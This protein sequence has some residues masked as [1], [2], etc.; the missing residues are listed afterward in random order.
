MPPKAPKVKAPKVVPVVADAGPPPNLDFI[1]HRIAVYD[2][3]KAAA[4]AELASKPREPITVTLPDGRQIAGTS[5]E[6]TPYDIARGISKSLADRTVISRVNGTLWDLMRPFEGSANVELL[7]F[8]DEE[9]K[10]VYWH[11]SA[12]ILGEAAEKTFGCHLCFGPPTD[13]GFFY[14]FGMPAEDGEGKPNAHSAVTDDDEKRIAS[15]MEGIVRERQPFERLVMTKANL[16]EMF[17]FNKYKQVLIN[18][19]IPDGTSTTVYRCG[20]L[21]DLCLGPHVVDTGRI[22]AFA[23]LKHSASYFLGDAKNDSLQRVYG[24][25]FPDKKLLSDY[26]KFLE[27]AAKKD[28]RRIGQDQELFFFHKMSPGSPF[29]LPHGMRIFNALKSFIVSEY[30]KRD[31]VEVMSPNMFNA[32]LWRTSGHWQHYQED[33]F[34]LE[35]EKQQWGLKPM[36]CPGHCLIF[37]SRERSYRELPLRMAEFGVLHRNEASGALSGLTR[38]RRFIQDDTHIFCQEDQIG[39]EIRDQFDFLQTVYG[40]LGMKFRLKLSTRPEQYLGHIDTWNRAEATLQKALDEFSEK[41]GDEWELN[42]GD[43]AFY[44]PKVDIQIMDA[45]RRWHQC[46]TVQL[47]F[48]LPQQFNL[49]YMSAASS[50]PADAAKADE[51]PAERP[52]EA[53]AAAEAAPAEA[54]S[55]EAAPADG[56]IPAGGPVVLPL[57][58]GYA[59][60]VMIHRAVLGSFERFIATLSEHFGGKWPFWM[61]PRQILLVPV[62]AD[63]EDYVR[64]VH[65]VLKAKGFYVDSDLGANT[66]N[67]KIRNGQ[68]LQY[69]YIFVLGSKEM[70][71]RSVSIRI[72]DSKGDLTTLSLDQ[73]VERLVKLREDKGLDMDLSDQVGTK[74]EEKTEKTEKAEN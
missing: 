32:D 26:M 22:K 41:T 33:M 46:A 35:I 45:L 7:D 10:R 42:P 24:I 65:K 73:V 47:D 53:P 63:A 34:T 69:N 57:A 68:V 62:M 58:P 28:H 60:P 1:P 38:V 21:I 40:K 74:V 27:E 11:S 37:G 23:V 18:S 30:H 2:R 17:K 39:E 64:E 49:S 6:T 20:P 3:L 67:K 8:E 4:D 44:G 66:M 43:G 50:N 56:A 55:A 15:L 31:Y 48:Q 70:Q 51:T 12:H 52:A 25:S 5:Y 19:K 71:D 54:A 16:L 29:F 59:R 61:S 14:D 72:R 36:N 13:E 9:A